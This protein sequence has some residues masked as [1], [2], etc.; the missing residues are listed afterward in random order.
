MNAADIQQL[1]LGS[2][3][4]IS[5]VVFV[6]VLFIGFCVLVVEIVKAKKTAGSWK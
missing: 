4:G 3:N 6:L 2:Q 5:T 1:V